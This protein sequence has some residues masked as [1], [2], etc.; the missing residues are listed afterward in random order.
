MRDSMVFYRSYME[1]L[2]ALPEEQ[3]HMLFDA[4]IAYSLDNKIPDF[5]GV[6]K[7][8]FLLMKPQIDANNK[9]YENGKKGA[10]SGK[11][12]GRPPKN[13]DEENPNETPKKPQDNPNG[14][15]S[16]NPKIIQNNPNETPN[17]NENDIYESKKVS[18]KN[19][20]ARARAR[21]HFESNGDI[22]PGDE[23]YLS[24]Q[25]IM[26][27]FGVS[28]R[29]RDV[30]TEFLRNSY[31]NKHIISNET[32]GEIIVTLDQKYK[33]DEQSKINSVKRAIRG[34]YI[35]IKERL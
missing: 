22:Y 14:D 21:E 4:I 8:L 23:R 19:N 30:L 15:N 20:N 33:D 3:R 25:E 7:A 18:K 35:N 26:T 31:L 11:N 2:S 1:A 12:G 32:L 34:G 6:N 5:D 16:E 13:K 27:T 24:H 9:R 17:E 29:L 10:G 28:E